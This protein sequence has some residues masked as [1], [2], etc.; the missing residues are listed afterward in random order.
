MVIPHNGIE[1]WINAL[2]LT[3]DTDWRPWFVTGQVAGLV[4]LIIFTR[5]PF[6]FFVISDYFYISNNVSFCLILDTR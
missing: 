5:L 6:F 3:L 4:F 1:Q 2:D